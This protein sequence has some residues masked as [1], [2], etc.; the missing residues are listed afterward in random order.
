MASRVL[1]LQTLD[2][3]PPLERFVEATIDAMSL[4]YPDM[5]WNDLGADRPN[6]HFYRHTWRR[7]QAPWTIVEHFA[8]NSIRATW[9][10]VQGED[11]PDVT[12]IE[13]LLRPVL[14]V[15]APKELLE[16]VLR[17]CG[18]ESL[19]AR[20]ALAHVGREVPQAL[21]TCIEQALKSEDLGTFAAACMAAAMLPSPSFTPILEARRRNDP[22]LARLIE[23][24][25]ARAG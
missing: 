6:D 21:T 4:T 5:Q 15:E 19:L 22:A 10:E 3:S 12:R 8:D 11:D 25:I 2:S 20:T 9:I 1:V 16:R 23:S 17:N 24:T 14:P 13:G 18:N 7:A